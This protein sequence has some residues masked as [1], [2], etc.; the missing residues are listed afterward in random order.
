MPD[1]SHKHG[2]G[3]GPA[4]ESVFSH[5]TGADKLLIVV[6]LVLSIFSYAMVKDTFPPGSYAVISVENREVARIRLQ[7]EFHRYNLQSTI[8]PIVVERKDNRVRVTKVSCP[9][10]ICRKMGWID[11]SGGI[12]VCAPG[13]VLIRV[14]GE[15][16]SDL[17]SLTR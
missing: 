8:G 4:E 2:T 14:A 6:L 12:I 9:N 1:V 13:K 5:L 10:K 3:P 16:T 11:S 7:D 15:E 17:D